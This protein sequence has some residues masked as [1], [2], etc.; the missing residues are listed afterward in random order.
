MTPMGE[1]PGVADEF[2]EWYVVVQAAKWL[3]VKP[4]DLL[5]QPVWW[6]HWGLAGRAAEAKAEKTL[7]ERAAARAKSK[8][9]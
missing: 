1:E 7:N 5:E 2:P 3:G 4:W 8:R 6:L 9:R